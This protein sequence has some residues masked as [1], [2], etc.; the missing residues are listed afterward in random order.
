MERPQDHACVRGAAHGLLAALCPDLGCMR[1]G[2]CSA[3]GI[4]FKPTGTPGAYGAVIEGT[5]KMELPDMMMKPTSTP[6]AYGAVIEGAPKWGLPDMMMK[7]TSTP[8]AYGAV[9]EGTPKWELPDMMLKPTS[10]PGAYGA[11]TEGTP[12]WE[13]P[14]MMMKPTSTP[15][16]YGSVTEGA[17]KWELPTWNFTMPTKAPKIM[18]PKPNML[19][20]LTFN[21]TGK[22]KIN[23]NATMLLGNLTQCAT[24]PQCNAHA[25]NQ[26]AACAPHCCA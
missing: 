15:G 23:L 7:P 13:L 11:V 4:F 10:T 26:R 21:G 12:K 17:P 14:D 6:G 5:P 19:P 20:G 22:H 24:R 9:T 25:A 1:A 2:P 16:A 3:Q 8:G 18:L